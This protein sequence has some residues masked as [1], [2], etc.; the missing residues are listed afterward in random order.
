MGPSCSSDHVNCGDMA[1]CKDEG[2][3]WTRKCSRKL[4][5]GK[6]YKRRIALKCPLTCNRCNQVY[7]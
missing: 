6:C 5:K 2:G 1:S 7:G 4:R 3:K